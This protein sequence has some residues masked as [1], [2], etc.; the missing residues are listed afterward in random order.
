[1]RTPY[2]I[3]AALVILIL[4]LW[5]GLYLSGFL[6]IF[7]LDLG[8]RVS[9]GWNTYW[10][11]WQ[12]LDLPQFAPYTMRIK[13]G[14]GVG[15]GLPLLLWL[16]TLYLLAPLRRQ[17][18]ASGQTARQP[19]LP[20]SGR[21]PAMAA[22]SM[23]NRISH[24]QENDMNLKQMAVTAVLATAALTPAVS[25]EASGGYTLPAEQSGLTIHL[26][27]H[28]REIYEITVTIHDAPGPLEPG[29]GTIQYGV[30]DPEIKKCVPHH[31]LDKNG[32]YN[33]Y[34]TSPA[35]IALDDGINKQIGNVYKT[36]LAMDFVVG[37]N[38]YGKGV[39]HWGFSDLQMDI[40]RQDKQSNIRIR[41]PLDISEDEIELGKG[42]ITYF[43]KSDYTD[44]REDSD[45]AE[46]FGEDDY[47]KTPEQER[48][49]F[50][51][52]TVSA[53]KVTPTPALQE[54]IWNQYNH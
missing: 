36:Y 15:F 42:N 21:P 2:K 54:W 16:W 22:D 1:M 27:R 19:G 9:L 50:F 37:E 49:K 4:A 6:L 14:G 45:S 41:F 20:P 18:G 23:F 3:L 48:S 34:Y 28:P 33:I 5:A 24:E 26:N 43:L 35:H 53:K 39:C 46:I 10:R 25:A 51:S 12:A 30:F 29:G 32:D 13:I 17:P 40:V 7:L 47:L 38:Y 31:M 11:Y 44:S 8:D 52:I